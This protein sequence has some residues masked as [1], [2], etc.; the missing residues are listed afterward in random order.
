MKTKSFVEQIEGHKSLG[1]QRLTCYFIKMQQN[2][3]QNSRFRKARGT[4]RAREPRVWR[5]RASHAHSPFLHS[6]KTFRLN[7][8]C[9]SRSQKN[10]TFLQS[11][12]TIENQPICLIWLLCLNSLTLDTSPSHFLHISVERESLSVIKFHT[13]FESSRQDFCHCSFFSST[14]NTKQVAALECIAAKPANW[15]SGMNFSESWLL[16]KHQ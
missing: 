9:C 11:S 16:H 6:L 12:S 1:G 8:D 5:G 15:I 2:R 3:L 7:M 4:V 14:E 10:T 13:H